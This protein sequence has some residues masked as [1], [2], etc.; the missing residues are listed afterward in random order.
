MSPR[1]RMPLRGRVRPVSDKSLTHRGLILGALAQGTTRLGQPNPGRDCDATALALGRLGVDVQRDGAAWILR[2]GVSEWREPEDVLD[3]GN[4]G[5]GL[6]LLAGALSGFSFLSVLTG[7]A[8]LRERPMERILTPLR[9]MGATLESRCGGRAPLVVR[10][11][12]LHGFDYEP[13]VASAQVKSAVLLAA[14]SG[15]RASVRVREAA[16]TRDHTETL[17]WYLGADF[18]REGEWL[19]VRRNVHEHALHARSW[20]VPGDP[21]AAAFFLVGAALAPGSDL[22]ITDLGLNP[23][24]LGAFDVLRRMGAAL[25]VEAEV[26]AAGQEGPEPVGTVRVRGGELRATVVEPAEV[27]RLIDEIPVLALAAALAQGTSEFRGIGELRHK[28]SDRVR[29]T[30]EMLHTL[31]ARAEAE[32]DTLRVHGSPRLHGGR[33]CTRGDHRIAM[34]AFIAQGLVEETVEVDEVEMIATSDP[35]FLETLGR[36]R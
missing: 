25:E 29:S 23:T 3:L 21:S 32:G 16:P 11:G 35:T 13:P 18:R 5:T 15:A 24:R 28:E 4:S 12:D 7:D 8:S 9:S 27:P 33:V 26:P 1:T 30:I 34:S 36:V 2:G 17:L 14:L 19:V 10:G 6:R 31:G 22:L 20:N